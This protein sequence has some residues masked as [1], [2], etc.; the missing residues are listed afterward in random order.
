MN[1]DSFR[2]IQPVAPKPS[3]SSDTIFLDVP[4]RLTFLALIQDF[5][6]AP[7]G[8]IFNGDRISR[9]DPNYSATALCIRALLPLTSLRIDP[10]NLPIFSLLTIYMGNLKNDT[11]MVQIAHSSYTAALEKSRPHIQRVIDNGHHTAQSRANLDLILLLAI[12]F[13]AFEV[14]ITI[15]RRMG[16]SQSLTWFPDYFYTVR[17]RGRLLRSSFDPHEGCFEHFAA[18]WPV[19]SNYST[20]STSF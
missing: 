11:K 4:G 16:T 14:R 2:K 3:P 6:P 5:K 18:L 13:L 12:T 19:Q 1:S 7:Q 17:K 9:D 10:L 8:G 15:I 20:N